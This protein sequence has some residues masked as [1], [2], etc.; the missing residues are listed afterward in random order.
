[1]W[2]HT[3]QDRSMSAVQNAEDDAAR[4]YEH[5]FGLMDAVSEGESSEKC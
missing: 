2:V 1:M 3:G 4:Y 5:M